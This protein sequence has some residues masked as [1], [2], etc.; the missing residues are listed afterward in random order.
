MPW[1]YNTS[2]E[3]RVRLALAEIR[4]RGLWDAAQVL[5]QE[6]TALRAERR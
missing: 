3:E 6:I 4:Q 1:K 2:Q 5:E